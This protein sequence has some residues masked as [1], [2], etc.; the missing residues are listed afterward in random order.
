MKKQLL[1]IAMGVLCPYQLFAGGILTNA[2]QSASYIRMLARD[3][4]TE[5]DAAYYN[6]AGLV[7]LSD[8]FHISLNNQTIFQ[9]R[10]IDN[11]YPL[12]NKSSYSGNVTI[13]FL[14][15]A[16]AI[17]KH[18][19]WAFSAS[20]TA[21][22]GGGKASYNK[23]LPSFELPISNIPSALKAAGIPT[24]NYS[25]D[26]TFDGSSVFYGYQAGASYEINK[27]IAVYAGF[28]VV[29]AVNTYNGSIRNILINPVHPYNANG[30][31]NLTSATAFFGTLAAAANGAVTKLDPAISQGAGVYTIDQMV[32]SSQ[33]SAADG[34]AL[35]A[36]LG[37]SYNNAMTL[38]EVQ[39]AY[40]TNAATMSTY[41]ASTA[42]KYVD[43]K[44][45][46]L[47]VAP[48][49]GANITPIENLNIGIRYEFI[50]KLELKNKTKTDGTGKFPDGAKINSDVPAVLSVGVDYKV[51]PDLKVSAGLHHYF[52]KNTNWDGKEKLINNN[53][54]ELAA[55]L[56]Y[57][58]NKKIAISAGYL[59]GQTGV[60]QGY[61]TDISYSLSSNTVGFGGR[62]KITDNLDLNL[63]MSY[64]AYIEGER[65]SKIN[66]IDVKETYNRS[67]LVYSIGIDYHF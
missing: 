42:D 2:N 3:A 39:T 56:E 50:T 25:V 15:S 47:S 62:A 21:T 51:F 26:L 59:Y 32:A 46:G 38:S 55:G 17:Y 18:N 23:G 19:K 43:V 54:Y 60:G 24:D 52:D 30:S 58:I 1:W 7:K 16:F 6:P 41:S 65:F 4:S 5:A 10:T 35:K 44:Q 31:G 27:M 11:S 9:N 66:N 64:T 63:G 67:N 37:A 34:A 28:R 36:G 48:I 57:D 13:P 45:T 49:L 14:P 20:F 8:G 61:Q 53:L 29:N 33:M 22:A 40:K 12:L